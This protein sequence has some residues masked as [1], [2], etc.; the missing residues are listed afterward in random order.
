MNYRDEN[1]RRESD[2]ENGEDGKKNIREY[3]G[4]LYPG[5]SAGGERG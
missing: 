2:G 5:G 1:G 4:R 3:E